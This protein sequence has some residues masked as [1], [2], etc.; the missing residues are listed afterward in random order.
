M[1]RKRAFKKRVDY[2]NRGRVRAAMGYRPTGVTRL[3]SRRQGQPGYTGPSG[4]A[5]PDTVAPGKTQDE[6]TGGGTGE[7]GEGAA[8]AQ[9]LYEAEQA[10]L[11][12]MDKQSLGNTDNKLESVTDMINP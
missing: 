3:G 11:A 10:L 9:K 6:L 8:E 2:R 7:A 4:G 5:G 1:A 12:E